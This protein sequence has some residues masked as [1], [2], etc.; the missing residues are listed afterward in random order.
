MN[1]KIKVHYVVGRVDDNSCDVNDS[2]A[3]DIRLKTMDEIHISMSELLCA[4]K[5]IIS[6]S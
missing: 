2:F 4:R 6:L 1:D 3:K 5:I